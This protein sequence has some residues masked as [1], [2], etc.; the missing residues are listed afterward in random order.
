MCVCP[1]SLT[2][3]VLLVTTVV[4]EVFLI[5][6]VVAAVALIGTVTS[7]TPLTFGILIAVPRLGAVPLPPPVTCEAVTV[8]AWTPVT[9]V[10]LDWTPVTDVV[11]DCTPIIEIS[12][13]RV[14]GTCVCESAACVAG[15]NESSPW[16]NDAAVPAV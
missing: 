14:G 5:G 7:V 10:V 15:V 6:T 9:D 3:C 2:V 13:P 11:L 8:E 12:V 1:L 4:V 16:V